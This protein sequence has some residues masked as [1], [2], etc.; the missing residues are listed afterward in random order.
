MQRATRPDREILDAWVT[1][2]GGRV[3]EATSLKLLPAAVIAAVHPVWRPGRWHPMRSLWWLAL[4]TLAL[5][6]E[7]WLIRRGGGA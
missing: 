5:S 4:F 6:A 1:A 3:F 2:H 7:W